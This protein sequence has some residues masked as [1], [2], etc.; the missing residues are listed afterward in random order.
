[1]VPEQRWVLCAAA[2]VTL[3]SCTAPVSKASA[4]DRIT[5]AGTERC[6]FVT[7]RCEPFEADAGDPSACAADTDCPATAKWCDPGSLSCVECRGDDDCPTGLCDPAPRACVAQPDTCQTARQVDLST[8]SATVR[9]NTARAIDDFKAA[10]AMP[11]SAAPDLVYSFTL[12]GP[13]RVVAVATPAPGSV[14]RPVLALRSSCD[15]TDPASNLQCSFMAPG[16][17]AVRLSAELAAGT[18]WLWVDADGNSAGSFELTLTAEVPALGD[19]CQSPFVI[20]PFTA[21]TELSGDTRGAQNDAEGS[22]AGARGA[23]VVY[24]LDLTAA[25]RVTAELVPET[26]GFA[27]ALYLRRAPCGSAQLASQ[28]GCVSAGAAAPHPLVLDVPR[29]EPGSYY[30]FVDGDLGAD[31]KP[32]AGAFK[33]KLALAPPL[34]TPA[35]DTCAG[36]EPIDPPVGGYGLTSLSGTTAF[37]VSDGAGC[38][39][40]GPDV[41]YSLTVP[42][43]RRL[44]L[45][46]APAAGSALVPVL[47][48]RKPGACDS[49]AALDS[50]GCNVASQPGSPASLWVPQLAAGTYF[51]WVDG[52]AGSKGAFHLTVELLAPSSAPP[53]DTCA[54]AQLLFP[55]SGPVTVTGT[56]TGATVDANLSCTLPL[57]SSNSPDVVYE[58]AVPSL[59]SL[60]LDLQAAAGSTLLPVMALRRPGACPSGAPTDEL[61]CGFGDPEF[62]DRAVYNLPALD[63]GSYFLWVDGDLGSQGAFSLRASLGPPVAPPVNDDCFGTPVLLQPRVG[64]SGDTRGA[65]N[66]SM[67]DCGPLP[68]VSGEAARDVVFEIDLAAA[69]TVAITVT[70]DLTDG[71]LFRPAVYVR[72]PGAMACSSFLAADQKGCAVATAYGQPV[73][74][75]V[76]NLPAGTYSVWVDGAGLSSGKFTLKYE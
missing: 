50:L 55:A 4:C 76:P 68:G 2:L 61:V 37:A 38:G 72:G 8:G 70:P 44:N 43:P 49:E 1:V 7:S 30:F 45:R 63:P 21:Q 75:T 74:L 12:A 67:G 18:Y 31:S 60:A 53:N 54:S 32:S 34:G 17:V 39:G 56:T 58:I 13:R 24:R 20:P 16:E 51:V 59:Q 25:S 26:A 28:L 46:A 5:C 3:A 41:V 27:A 11:G 47:Y 71:S 14:F 10:C 9:G 40:S 42:G 66:D 35:N 33:L 23:D 64:V 65:A 6:N 48:L 52:A 57:S 22:C 36:A 15:A 73:S 29:L 19:T 62:S 69:Q